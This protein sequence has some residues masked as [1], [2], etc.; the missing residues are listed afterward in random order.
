M[1]R[2]TRTAGRF[3]CF[4]MLAALLAPAAHA[5]N[6]KD[7]ISNCALWLRGD[8]EVETSGGKVTFWRDQSG[9]DRDASQG[10][11]P[12][13]PTLVASALNG[14]PVIRFDGG[15]GLTLGNIGSA[16]P[17]AAT[18]FVVSTINN[19]NNYNL[20]TTRVK[21]EEWAPGNPSPGFADT[22][23]RT[24]YGATGNDGY[25][26]VFTHPHT[27]VPV[28]AAPPNSGSHVFAVESSITRWAMWVDDRVAPE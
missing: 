16:F 22:W 10:S 12:D 20:F 4:V 7:D 26:G 17:S 19:D 5:F 14:Q 3:L 6:P 9:N 28:L 21:T 13:T 8:M 24:S 11:A 15:D 2:I 25:N 23:W 27:Y 1:S 18:L